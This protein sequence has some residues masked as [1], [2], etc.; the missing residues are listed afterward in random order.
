[1]RFK[2]LDS[3]GNYKV[4]VYKTTLFMRFVK[5]EYSHLKC[6]AHFPF[7]RE[8]QIFTHVLLLMKDF[9]L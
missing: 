9:R 4:T 7:L 8:Q 3:S 2:G 6:A 5:L 1:M